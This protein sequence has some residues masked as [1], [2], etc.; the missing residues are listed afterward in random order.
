M[1]ITA[2]GTVHALDA[3]EGTLERSES[4]SASYFGVISRRHEVCMECDRL[5]NHHY[6]TVGVCA[7]V[8]TEVHGA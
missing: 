1:C 6:R 3:Q 8:D 4:V 5:H 7:E 2:A